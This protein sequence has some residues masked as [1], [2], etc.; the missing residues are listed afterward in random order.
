M[1]QSGGAHC[2]GRKAL[3]Y[4]HRNYEPPQSPFI[5]WKFDNEKTTGVVRASARKL[6]AGLWQLR[7][8]EISWD[9]KI[10][11]DACPSDPSP[12]QPQVILIYFLVFFVLSKNYFLSIW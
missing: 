9:Q 1:N 5:H 6:A 8:S 7:F 2:R 11:F 10:K 3:T 4:R 12:P